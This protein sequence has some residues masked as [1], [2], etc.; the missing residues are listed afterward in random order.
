MARGANC[1]CTPYTGCFHKHYQVIPPK[2]EVHGI[3]PNRSEGVHESE[4][5]LEVTAVN[6]AILKTVVFYKVI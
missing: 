2:H 6:N 4:Y 1:Y 5:F 3:Y